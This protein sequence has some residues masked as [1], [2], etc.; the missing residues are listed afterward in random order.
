MI[1]TNNKRTT[2]NLFLFIIVFILV[3]P[4]AQGRW[5]RMR[6]S[7]PAFAVVVSTPND[8]VLGI[9]EERLHFKMISGCWAGKTYGRKHLLKLQRNRSTQQPSTG[10]PVYGG[11]ITE[12]FDSLRSEYPNKHSVYGLFLRDEKAIVV[13]T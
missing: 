11:H 2:R 4:T 5:C 7:T 6:L 1:T 9:L 12:K 8:E 13:R 10:Q 3:T